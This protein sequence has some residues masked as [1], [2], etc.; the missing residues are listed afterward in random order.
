MYLSHKIKISYCSS[1]THFNIFSKDVEII[2]K[3]TPILK[4]ENLYAFP[5]LDSCNV[6]INFSHSLSN[7]TISFNQPFFFSIQTNISSIS[8]SFISET[9]E[10]WAKA[11]TFFYSQL[12]N[13]SFPNSNYNPFICNRIDEI[14]NIINATRTY[15][16]ISPSILWPKVKKIYETF[17]SERSVLLHNDEILSIAA[18][19]LFP[20]TLMAIRV[21]ILNK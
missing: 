7:T 6:Y 16:S 9:I 1:F 17:F 8:T 2:G 12:K 10:K 5:I 15:P 21:F 3:H 4:F 14:S 18:P 11:D 13:L 20:A 19:V